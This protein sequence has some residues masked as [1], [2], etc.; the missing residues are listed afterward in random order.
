MQ[1]HSMCALAVAAYVW[2]RPKPV[3]K[4]YLGEKFSVEI[5]YETQS[6]ERKQLEYKIEITQRDTKEEKMVVRAIR[7]HGGL[8]CRLTLERNSSAEGSKVTV[9]HSQ[10]HV[11]GLREIYEL[12]NKYTRSGH[13]V[14]SMKY[15]RF[16]ATFSD[17]DDR[18]N[19][20]L[21]TDIC[22]EGRINQFRRVRYSTKL[23]VL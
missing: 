4:K 18:K 7:S 15:N 21:E 10:Q 19:G 9:R 12:H 1:P 6:R 16:D 22:L 8:D 2:N 23:R 3:D 13:H 14:N 5:E 20:T 11:A 17:D